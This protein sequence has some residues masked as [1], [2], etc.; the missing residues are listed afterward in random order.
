M[1]KSEKTGIAT[2]D[3][4]CKSYICWK[5]AFLNLLQMCSPSLQ[6]IFLWTLLNGGGLTCI[7]QLA[8]PEHRDDDQQVP[9]HINHRGEDQDTGQD[10]DDPGG[11]G[12][13]LRGKAALQLP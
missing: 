5:A 6:I 9:Q 7:P 13:R 12:G 4:Y 2:V 10:G 1:I 3:T 8:V 11:A